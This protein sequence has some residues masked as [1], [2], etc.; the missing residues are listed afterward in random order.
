MKIPFLAVAGAVASLSFLLWEQNG[1]AGPPVVAESWRVTACE[2]HARVW[3][4][5]ELVADQATSQTTP[6]QHRYVELATGLH[7]FEIGQYVDDSPVAARRWRASRNINSST[8]PTSRRMSWIFWRL[9]TSDSNLESWGWLFYDSSS[10][11]SVLIAELKSSVGQ[12]SPS[13]N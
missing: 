1:F 7:R 12:L 8:R 4:S 6:H 3:E 9:M 11:Q 2:A 5:V 10:G 13:K